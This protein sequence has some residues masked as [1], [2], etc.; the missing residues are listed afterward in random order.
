MICQMS[1][2]AGRSS[3]PSL[4]KPCEV[5]GPH[6][7]ELSKVALEGAKQITIRGVHPQHGNDAARMRRIKLRLQAPQHF[8]SRLPEPHLVQRTCTMHFSM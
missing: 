3:S 7:G 4:S 1:G 8:K 6:P 2:R 5:F